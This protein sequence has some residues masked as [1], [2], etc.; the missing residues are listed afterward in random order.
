M[1]AVQSVLPSGAGT[2][3][4][5]AVVPAGVDCSDFLAFEELLK[6]MRKIDD[7]IIYAINNSIPTTSFVSRQ[8]Q[9]TSGAAAAVGQEHPATTRCRQLHQALQDSH[10]QRDSLIKAC[11]QQTAE[12]IARLNEVIESGGGSASERRLR[13]QQGAQ[14][15][16]LRK[17]LNV[18]EVIQDRSS[19]ILHDKCRPFFRPPRQP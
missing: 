14:L 9:E 6:T 15:R 17:E 1:T 5:A 12:R 2:A 3:P 19:A 4:L 18:E 8:Q 10:T 7:N 11:I 13:S 16:L